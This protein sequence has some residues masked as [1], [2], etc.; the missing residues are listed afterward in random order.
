MPI[1][2]ELT[3]FSALDVTTVVREPRGDH[4]K[5]CAHLGIATNNR[6]EVWLAFRPIDANLVTDLAEAINAVL[7]KH[8]V[9]RAS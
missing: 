9:G 3:G 8:D 6:D 2:L 1:N 5:G 4:D 7:V